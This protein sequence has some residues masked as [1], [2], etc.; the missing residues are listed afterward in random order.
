MATKKTTPTTGPDGDVA[1]DQRQPLDIM[2]MAIGIHGGQSQPID[3][4]GVTLSVRRNFTGEEAYAYIS[5]FSAEER[6]NPAEFIDMNIGMLSD[7]DEETKEAFK[8]EAL[9]LPVAVLTRVLVSMGKI[10]GLRAGDG[11]FFPGPIG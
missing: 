4:N 1:E 11:N 6:P 2:E 8:Q 7:S 3:L 10:A 5:M 9:R